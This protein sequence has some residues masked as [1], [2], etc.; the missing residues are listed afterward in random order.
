M[1]PIEP[2]ENFRPPHGF[3]VPE[4][5]F[6]QLPTR[7]MH[8]TAYASATPQAQS[9][10]L[11]R[12]K[13]VWAGVGMAAAFTG[14]FLATQ[15]FDQEAAPLNPDAALAQVSHQEIVHYLV[16]DV[17]VETADIAEE[18]PHTAPPVQ[19]LEFLEVTQEDVNLDDAME[20]ITDEFESPIDSHNEN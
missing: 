5:Y 14:A 3:S 8:R 12:L 6:E 17:Q 1:K 20:V 11:V 10:W 16:N 15:Y 7:V 9:S 13:T 18:V 4:G 2:S 19:E